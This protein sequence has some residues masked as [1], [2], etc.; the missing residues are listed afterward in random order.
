ML[1]N[2]ASLIKNLGDVQ[3]SDFESASKDKTVENNFLF[4]ISLRLKRILLTQS[5]Q[6]RC[7][8]HPN[9]VGSPGVLRLELQFGSLATVRA[10]SDS[11]VQSFSST[12]QLGSPNPTLRS[13]SSLS[14]PLQTIKKI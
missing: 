7:P 1:S 12:L 4:L 11:S 13:D 6:G 9:S 3:L 10:S 8:E 2:A 14:L 5:N